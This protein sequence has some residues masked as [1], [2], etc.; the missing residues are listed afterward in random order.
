MSK[1]R[2]WRDQPADLPVQQ[3]VKV[4][5]FI[6]LMTAKALRLDIPPSV[7]VRADEV[8]EQWRS[9]AGNASIRSQ[10]HP[11]EWTSLGKGQCAP[12]T[13]HGATVHQFSALNLSGE[14]GR[15]RPSTL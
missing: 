1:G 9:Q 2:S 15:R 8:V 4:E 3:A 14:A 6:N 11:N 10:R 7:L 5:L 12:E 13:G